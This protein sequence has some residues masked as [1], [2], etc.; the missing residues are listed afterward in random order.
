MCYFS[1]EKSNGAAPAE[2]AKKRGRPTIRAKEILTAA[3][4]IKI[5]NT[6]LSIFH[7]ER[8]LICFY[9]LVSKRKKSCP[10]VRAEITEYCFHC[11]FHGERAKK[12]RAFAD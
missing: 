12:K 7:A 10:T 3:R 1:S 4:H 5:P 2:G 9:F 6:A 11:G 8:L